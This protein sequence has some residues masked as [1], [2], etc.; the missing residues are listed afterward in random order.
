MRKIDLS[1]VVLNQDEWSK[2]GYSFGEASQLRVIGWSGRCGNN[3]LYVMK[4]SKCCED[5]E[6]FGQGTFTLPKAGILRGVFPCGC[7][8]TPKWDKE[9]WEIKI[10]RRALELNA[11]FL[12]FSVDW[13]G[14][15]TRVRMDCNKHGEWSTGRLDTLL[16]AKQGCPLCGNDLVSIKKTKPDD[17]M[18]KSFLASGSFHPDTKFWRSERKTGQGVKAYWFYSCTD[19]GEVGESFSGGLQEGKKSCGCIQAQN[20][21]Y[22]NLI[23]YGSALYAV[24]FGIS[25]NPENRVRQQN[26]SS[27]YEI[28]KFLVYEFSGTSSCRA[29]EREC[30]K[31]LECGIVP[32]EDMPD[33]YTETTYVRNIN[34]IIS[35]YEK[36][37]GILYAQ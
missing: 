30:K 8:K 9:Q 1:D 21:A 25:S 19:C 29:A 4:C 36:H 10:K 16:N 24:K 31:E 7:S 27:N 5:P 32:R 35:I 18:V 14:K 34:D 33:G 3:K 26:S 37:G 6:L 2:Q 23:S 15:D 20:Q 28:V 12:G 13:V 22:I 11:Q 17:V